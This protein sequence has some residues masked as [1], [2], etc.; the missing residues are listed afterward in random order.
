VSVDVFWAEAIELPRPSAKV[1]TRT[2]AN[3]KTPL[4]FLPYLKRTL[5]ILRSQ[6]AP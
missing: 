1:T 6:V 2:F 3:C 5:I 4:F